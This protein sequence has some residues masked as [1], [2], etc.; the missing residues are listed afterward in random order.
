MDERYR[1]NFNMSIKQNLE[2]IRTIGIRKF[3]REQYKNHRCPD[4]GGL[5]SV[6]NGKCFHCD[7]ITR[8]VVVTDRR[9]KKTTG[10]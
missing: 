8:L 2:R 3:I 5:I 6:H 4:C 10:K 9:S 1:K 7:T